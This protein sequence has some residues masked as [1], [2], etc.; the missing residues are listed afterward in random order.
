[1]YLT[2]RII[3]SYLV[4]KRYLG[5]EVKERRKTTMAGSALSW[6]PLLIYYPHSGGANVSSTRHFTIV[7]RTTSKSAENN[8]KIGNRRTPTG[9]YPFATCRS[10]IPCIR[11]NHPHNDNWTT[12]IPPSNNNTTTNARPKITI[13]PSCFGRR[14]FQIIGR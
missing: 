11:L 3:L 9:T 4:Q 14:V 5:Y 2:V 10:I 1:M 6:T 13:I 8:I 12:T 7:P